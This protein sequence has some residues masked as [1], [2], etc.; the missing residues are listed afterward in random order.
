MEIGIKHL[1]L[2]I[3]ILI[4]LGV[5]Y[6]IISSRLYMQGVEGFDNS[7]DENKMS[8]ENDYS[9]IENLPL[10]EYIIKACYNSIY[11]PNIKKDPKNPTLVLE[12]RIAEGLSLIHI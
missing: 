9:Q 2:F 10:K 3:A 1:L 8:C 5:F 12:T 11:D 4:F 6:R 7:S